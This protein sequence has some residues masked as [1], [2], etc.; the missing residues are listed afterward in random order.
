M[1]LLYLLHICLNIY[2]LSTFCISVFHLSSPL[3]HHTEG[4]Y[5]NPTNPSTL[6]NFAPSVIQL[7]L[8]PESLRFSA[9]CIRKTHNIPS[10]LTM[11]N[12]I[13]TLPVSPKQVF[14][15]PH[16]LTLMIKASYLKPRCQTYEISLYCG[17]FHPSE[18]HVL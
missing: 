14:S 13:Q 12:L 9:D 17:S 15:A 6:H 11:P 7:S 18:C 4:H 5:S 2:T 8:K 16:T 1:A 10:M 3:H